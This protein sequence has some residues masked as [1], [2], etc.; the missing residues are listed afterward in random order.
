MTQLFTP[1][2]LAELKAAYGK[3]ERIDPC[4]PA[5]GAVIR[6][7]D[8]A[9]APALRQIVDADI[10]FLR[11]LAANRLATRE[12][13]LTAIYAKTHADYKGVTAGQKSIMILRG[14]TCIVALD[15]LTNAEI[16]YLLPR[17]FT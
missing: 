11:H 12:R 6:L 3:L 9:E 7:L 5:Y 1:D 10:K 16:A 17:D 2:Q 8:A 15:A 4:A 14:G 13:K